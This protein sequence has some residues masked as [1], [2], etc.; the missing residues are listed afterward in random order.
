MNELLERYVQ[1][2]GDDDPPWPVPATLA[3][4]AA[5]ELR[6][7][8]GGALYGETAQAFAL[9]ASI[10]L[11]RGACWNALDLPDCS[12]YDARVILSAE[13]GVNNPGDWVGYLSGVLDPASPGDI[14][15]ILQVR[16]DLIRAC[17]GDLPAA[18]VDGLHDW[19]H[20]TE[21]SDSAHERLAQLAPRIT[22]VDVWLTGAGLQAAG[23]HVNTVVGYQAAYAVSTICLGAKAGY[24]DHAAVTQSLLAARDLIGTRCASW[25]EHAV[26]VVAGATLL[27]NPGE[28]HRRFE[29]VLS[30][31]ATCLID[32]ESP[33]R[34]LRFPC[35]T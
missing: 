8:P 5:G 14:E 15:A 9:G 16:A 23:N 28:E 4:A 20:R 27:A 6:A 21:Q 34:V 11:T 2:R 17:G 24:A 29:S 30:A 7:Q 32:P 1:T 25:H 13:L 12:V 3:A 35:Q 31:V 19:L 18:W 33:W 22:E 26:S 10:A